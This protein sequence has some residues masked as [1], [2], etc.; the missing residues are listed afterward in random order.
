MRRRTRRCAAI[1]VA[2]VAALALGATAC[3]CLWPR[4]DYAPGMFCAQ[5]NT[6]VVEHCVDASEGPGSAWSKAE[7][8]GELPIFMWARPPFSVPDAF[9]ASEGE[10]RAWFDNL[11]RAV[12]YVRDEQKHAESLRATLRGELLGLLLT[13]RRHQKQILEEEP[14]RAVDNFT[15]AMTDKAR[16]EEEP[17][18][19]ALA[20]DKQAMAV[21]QVVFDGARSDAA[22]LVS[23]Y[24][25]VA[26][27]FAGYRA[28]EATETAAYAALSKQA[29]RLDPDGLDG[30]EQAVLAAA[31]EASR[32]AN[33]LAAE[34]MTLSAEL[35]ALAVS[36]E[37]AIAPH[38]EVL[39]THGAVVP[40]MT[41]GALRSLG[42]ML[43]YTW[44]RVARSDATAT[45]LLG[46]IALRR[47]ALR[48]VQGDHGARE[49]IA[50]SRS[51]RASE[52]FREGARA[53]AAALSAAPPVSDKLG[54][55]LLADRCGELLALVQMRPLCEATGASWREAGCA[56]LRGRFDVAEEELRTGLPRKI[57]AGLAA[58]REKGMAAA[59][60]DAAQARLDAGDVKGAAIAYDAAVR[61]AEGA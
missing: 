48:V 56:E 54:L 58:L 3:G 18:A 5:A 29:S 31:R 26:A 49:A 52:R 23:R 10:L 11:D 34:I 30:A 43:G 37:E 14:V 8:D 46:G 61:G 24:A 2:A 12:A 27:R 51:R 1:V 57:A 60:L 16:A 20:A 15:R 50:R 39:A 36:F 55:P 19:A 53:R 9:V 13:Y 40:D 47:Q 6:S 4:E 45:A 41:S 59:A 44:R 32:A 21:V 35:Q 28:T 7:Q 17:L 38:R 42:A 22:P 25:A 33:E